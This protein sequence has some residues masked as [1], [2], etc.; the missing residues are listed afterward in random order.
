VR[1]LQK[2]FAKE[3]SRNILMPKISLDFWCEQQHLKAFMAN[4]FVEDVPFDLNAT[5]FLQYNKI[6]L[7]ESVSFIK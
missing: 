2:K 7:F 3:A 4:L 5:A 1:S 6:S